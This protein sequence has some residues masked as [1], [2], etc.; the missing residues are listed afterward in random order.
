MRSTGLVVSWRGGVGNFQWTTVPSILFYLIDWSMSIQ[1][2]SCINSAG[3]KQPV[4][5]VWTKPNPNGPIGS[6]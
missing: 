2:S 6:S 5:T 3:L 4:T 1:F